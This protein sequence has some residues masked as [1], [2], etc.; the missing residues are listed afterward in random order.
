MANQKDAALGGNEF[1]FQAAAL[2][3]AVPGLIPIPVVDS[4]G[5][6]FTAGFVSPGSA[7][8]GKNVID[9]AGFQ[10]EIVCSQAQGVIG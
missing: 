4:A 6:P 8:Y 5:P 9:L 7:G 3:S 1:Y 2:Q 10:G